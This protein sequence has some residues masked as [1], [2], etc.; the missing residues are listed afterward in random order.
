MNKLR[1]LICDP[2]AEGA[3]IGSVI[4]EPDLFAAVKEFVVVNEFVTEAKAIFGILDGMYKD[5]I[6]FDPVIL[7][8][9]FPPAESEMLTSY[10]VRAMETVPHGHNA[11]Y[12]A[13]LIHKKFIERDLSNLIQHG[14]MALEK[15]GLTVEEKIQTLSS[16]LSVAK[17]FGNEKKE[18]TVNSLIEKLLDDLTNGGA[19]PISTGFNNLDRYIEGLGK[20]QLILIA[21]A[22]SMGKTSMLMDIFIHCARIG[23][24]PYYYYLEM[25]AMQLT[26][27]MIMNIA[28]VGRPINPDDPNVQETKS[29]TQHWP[30]WIEPKPNRD[31]ERLCSI[32]ETQRQIKD[33]GVV[34][35]DHIQKITAPGRDGIAQMTN[36]SGRL[37]QLACDLEIPVVA[38]CQ[39]NRNTMQRDTH[40]PKLSDL[41]G[42]GTLEHDSDV[43]L[44]LHRDDYYREMEDEEPLLDGT[45]KCFVA[46]NRHG[47]KGVAKLIWFPEYC[48]FRDSCAEGIF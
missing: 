48:S 30:A 29:I 11:V 23:A 12:Y 38:A 28:R 10:L 19:E 46:K 4:L 25:L 15:D 7:R 16:M 45:A 18:M 17:N 14:Y 32:V 36:I 8:S 31:I 3:L 39:L 34:F 40:L 1:E 44:L 37:A 33:I 35:I 41:R 47:S 20:G 24:R 5:K 42:S 9:K 26:E 27:R 13:K 21:G 2:A 22:T 6:P 43:V